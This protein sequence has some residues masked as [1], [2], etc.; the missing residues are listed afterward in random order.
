LVV[1]AGTSRSSG[2][3]SLRTLPDSSRYSNPAE[4]YRLNLSR[5]FANEQGSGKKARDNKVVISA[6]QGLNEFKV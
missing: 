1:E 2:C 3:F 6:K 5:L 4:S